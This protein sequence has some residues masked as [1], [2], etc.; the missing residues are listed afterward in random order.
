MVGLVLL[1]AHPLPYSPGFFRLYT[2]THVFPFHPL[3]WSVVFQLPSDTV[4]YDIVP[5]NIK[6]NSFILFFTLIEAGFILNLE[7]AKH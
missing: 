5:C 7:N 6:Y 4:S 3:V 2:P 1:L